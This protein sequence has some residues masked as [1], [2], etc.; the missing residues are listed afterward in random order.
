MSGENEE[1]RA[2]GPLWG[3]A[4][5]VA[6]GSVV[7]MAIQVPAP[8][9]LQG[10]L[11]G[12]GL[13]TL[14]VGLVRGRRRPTVLWLV[15]GFA[16]AGGHGLHLAGERHLLARTIERPEPL[17]VRARLVVT[18]GWEQGRWGWRARVRVLEAHHDR[19]DVPPLRRCRL[20][21]RGDVRP[22]R[23]PRPGEV[24]RGLLSIRGSPESPLL[25]A[26]SQR[27]VEA[28]GRRR[29]LAALRDRLAGSLLRAAGTDVDRIRA[30]ELAATL[31]LGRRDLVPAARRD[32]WRRSGLAHVLAVSGLHVG[33]VGGVA[34][35]L[36][37]I[38]GASPTTT[39]VVLL[40]VLPSYALLAGASPS[41]VRAAAMGSIY[42]LARLSGRAIL[43]M[44]AVLLTATLLLL[45]DPA[46]VTEASFQLTVL[47]TA[48]LVRWAPPL[49]AAIPLPRWLAAA[50]AVPLIA[51]LAAAPLV[52]HHFR[53]LIP[54][55]AA[56]N[57]LVPWLLGP[58]VVSA[59]AAAAA[60]PV[61]GFI[62]VRLLDLVA[63]GAQLLWLV[64]EPGRAA[65][66][67][68]PP[69]PGWLLAALVAVGLVALLP[70]RPA[71]AGVL[72]Y[73][74]VVAGLV[75]W[76][77]V[78]PSARATSVELLPVSSGLAVRVDSGRDRVLMDGGGGLREASE[79]LAA[80]RVRRLDA[81]LASHGDEDHIAGL[82]RVVETTPVGVLVVPS[83]LGSSADAVP[84]IR[85]AR[86]R[87]IRVQPVARGSRITLRRAAFDVLW[88]PASITEGDENDRSLVAR[89][90]VDRADILLTADIGRSVERA[91][92]A[93]S[94]LRC[95]VL[96]VPHHGSRHSL[97][98]EL[99]QAASPEIALVP[100]GPGNLHHHPH[101][102]VLGRLAARAI[103]VR[104]PIFD[105]RCGARR[106]DNG[107]LAY[108]SE[109][110][111]RE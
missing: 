12:I 103:R 9:S 13:A 17:W 3:L 98:D 86:R 70:G 101:P 76:W 105:G 8:G 83:W 54:G 90:T 59:V 102:E 109:A 64:S 47:L 77:R 15:A 66:L 75:G 74:V 18:D 28:T 110:P 106:G 82:R 93:A 58:I 2:L 37:S 72:A 1:A 44:A 22:L 108:P 6:A 40:I 55:A 39:R 51:Q 78:A 24:V 29:P 63:A 49:A 57:L 61:A 25:V 88:P 43:P 97:S 71:R 67:V 68:P 26:S 62:A 111:R 60:A 10:L 79:L 52:A 85:A 81:V 5:G 7:S 14:V 96:V 100:A 48:A 65:E 20:E 33:L 19:V 80:T 107:W 69:V 50:L 35:L 30:A 91:L 41:A 36:L 31:A 95:A 73:L 11:L 16:L 32:G 21:I 23:L 84:L 99:L 94:D 27:L 38:A 104:A 87:G 42:L 92:A 56:A 34:W 46:L 89:V 45:V 4:A 53:S